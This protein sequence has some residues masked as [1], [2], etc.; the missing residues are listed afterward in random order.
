MLTHFDT[1]LFAKRQMKGKEITNNQHSISNIQVKYVGK[2][3]LLGNW[4]LDIGYWLLNIVEV[5]INRFRCFSTSSHGQN[6]GCATGDDI[7][8]GINAWF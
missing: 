6:Y 3:L 8:A 4:I 5:F 1:I 2:I 7:P